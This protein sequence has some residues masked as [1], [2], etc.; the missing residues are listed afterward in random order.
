MHARSAPSM[1]T[2]I[3]DER[4]RKQEKERGLRDRGR[5]REGCR[6]EGESERE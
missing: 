1:P 5:K 6:M 3:G 2:Y 4:T